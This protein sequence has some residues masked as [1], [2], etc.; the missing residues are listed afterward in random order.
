MDSSV[1]RN[2][3]GWDP[4]VYPQHG[5]QLTLESLEGKKL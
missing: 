4:K 1:A 2:R 5:M 3:F